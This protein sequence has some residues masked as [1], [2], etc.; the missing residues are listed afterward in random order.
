LAAVEALDDRASAPDGG[1]RTGCYPLDFL[2]FGF[3]VA[4]QRRG[5]FRSNKL[6]EVLRDGGKVGRKTPDYFSSVLVK[7][8]G[9]SDKAYPRQS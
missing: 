8:R 5:K 1:V 4:A 3:A 2:R 7:Q 6:G 9:W